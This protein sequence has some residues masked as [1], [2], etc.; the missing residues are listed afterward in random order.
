MSKL[1]KL[2]CFVLTL[3]VFASMF[4][5]PACAEEPEIPLTWEEYVAVNG[6]TSW[7]WNDAAD[8]IEA[9]ADKAMA[10]YAAGENDAA[11]TY[12]KATYWGYYETTGFERNVMT[13]ISGARVSEVELAFTNFRKAIKKD[14]GIEAA[15][16]KADILVGFLHEDALI[17]SPE[18][19]LNTAA[20]E[21][22]AVERVVPLTW[23]EYITANGIS[24]WNWNDAADAIEAVADKAMALYADG[25]NDEAYNYAKATYWGYYETTGFERNVMTRISGARVSEVELAFTNFRKAIKKD[26]GIEAAQEKAD[27][28]VGFLHEDALILSPEGALNTAASAAT[29]S[30]ET[31]AEVSTTSASTTGGSVAIFLGSFAIILREGLE[32]ILIVG[33]IIAYLVKS[34]NKKGVVPVYIGS[35]L[36]V[37]CSFIMAAIL[38]WLL[39]R[40]AEYHM[41]Q[42]IIEGI[43]ALTAVVVLFWVSNWMVS[44]SESA[45]WTSYIESKASAGSEK[46]SGFALA[47]TAWLAVFREGAEVILF[48]QPMLAEDRPDMV[49]AGFLVGVAALVVVFI[50]IRF[51]SIRLP[52]KP[53]FLGTSIL[54]AIM[55]ISFLGAGIKELIEGGVF[56]NFEWVIASPAWLSWIPY[57]DTLDVLGIYPLVGTI[58]PQLILTA[59]TVATFAIQIHRNNKVA[60]AAREK[61]GEA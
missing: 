26:N 56:D 45:T 47:F 12:A 6:I 41:S 51:V 27:I 2:F 32:A 13:R 25:E 11:Y 42:E 57:N 37:V 5:I 18:G 54:M 21:A 28:L 61:A 29:E 16:E 43:A 52:L 17:L 30:T 58:V 1:K 10:L 4:T 33:A 15:Q 31:V 23:E 39:S 24:S 19:A 40:S 48:Y 34:G 50:L 46:G 9:V 3:L 14:N 20:A 35:V 49:W 60:Q 38:N 36:G 53:F 7:N 8:A 22:P 44:K 55:C 59:I